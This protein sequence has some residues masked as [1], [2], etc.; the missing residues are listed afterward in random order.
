MEDRKTIF[1][2]ESFN[3]ALEY[4]PLRRSP[5][6]TRHYHMRFGSVGVALIEI[7]SKEQERLAGL[8]LVT[9]RDTQLADEPAAVHHGTA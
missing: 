7:R 5:E 9:K 6:E 1:S 3:F 2:L 8:P 4:L